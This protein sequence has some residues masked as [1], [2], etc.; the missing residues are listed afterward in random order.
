MHIDPACLFPVVQ[1][2]NKISCFQVINVG[3][4]DFR[5]TW[6]QDRGDLCDI[7]EERQSEEDGSSMLVESGSAWRKVNVQRVLDE[8]TKN[9]VKML[10]EEA[11]RKSKS[12]KYILLL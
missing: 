9:H 5:F 8:S 4:K 1:G 2:I 11:E 10:S 7:Y 3:G 6:S 12:R